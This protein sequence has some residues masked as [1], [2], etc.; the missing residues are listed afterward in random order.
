M[1]QGRGIEG[2]VVARC[3]LALCLTLILEPYCDRL[4]FHSSSLRYSLAVFSG[5]MG[6]LV[7]EVFEHHELDISEPLASAARG[8]GIDV[9]EANSFLRG[10]AGE[11]R[12][13][14]V[15]GIMVIHGEGVEG[16]TDGKLGKT[17]TDLFM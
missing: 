3:R 13:E 14:R 7:E 16:G 5:R 10:V 6:V 2:A 15:M 12:S 8:G 17:V 4:N 9:A 1:C 11:R